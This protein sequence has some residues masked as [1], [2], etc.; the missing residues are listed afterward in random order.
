[1]SYWKHMVSHIF[2]DLR[3]RKASNI[4]VI[5]SQEIPNLEHV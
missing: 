3:K 5:R 1:M 2:E 4:G